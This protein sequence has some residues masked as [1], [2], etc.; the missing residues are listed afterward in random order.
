MLARIHTDHAH[1]STLLSVLSAKAQRLKQGQ[2][3]NLSVIRD[4]VDYLQRYADQSH[5]PMEDILYQY[6][7]DKVGDT[8]QGEVHQLAIEHRKLREAT[9][10]LFDTLNMILNDAVVPRERLIADIEDFVRLQRTHLEQ[11]EVRVL[12]LLE[13]TLTDH[14]WQQIHRLVANKLVEDPLF[15]DTGDREFED[16]R[17]YLM[18]SESEQ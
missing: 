1:I 3:V 5:H 4:V 6:Y 12:P 10:Q 16:L 8:Q 15:G 13:R 17:E 7:L 9:D 18:N 14:D 2:E 11:E